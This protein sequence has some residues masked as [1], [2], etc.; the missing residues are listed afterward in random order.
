M[1][2]QTETGGGLRPQ[3]LPGLPCSPDPSHFS[4]LALLGIFRVHFRAGA[5]LLFHRLRPDGAWYCLFQTGEDPGGLRQ[6]SDGDALTGALDAVGDDKSATGP[7]RAALA[8]CFADPAFFVLEPAGPEGSVFTVGALAVPPQRSPST[9]DAALLRQVVRNLLDI[10]A[11]GVYREQLTRTSSDLEALVS[12]SRTITAASGLEKILDRIIHFLNATIGAES[13]GVLLYD[14]EQDALVLQRPAFGVID[15]KPYALFLRD[16]GKPGSGASLHVFRTLAPHIVN[17]PREDRVTHQ[18]LVEAVGARNT[19]TVPL[20][21]EGKAIGALHL[22]NKRGGGFTNEDAR[23]LSLL[24][25]QVAI[26]IHNASLL[27]K[28]ELANNLLKKSFTFHNELMDLLL[29]NQDLADITFALSRMIGRPVVLEDPFFRLLSFAPSGRDAPGLPD[30]VRQDPRFADFVSTLRQSRSLHPLPPSL[31]APRSPGRLMTM[32]CAGE[33]TMG[34]LSILTGENNLEELETIAVEQSTTVLALKI[35]QQQIAMEVEERITGEFLRAL[36]TGN[37]KS[38]QR[39][40]ERM[41]FVG[42]DL[43]K[44]YRI[45]LADGGETR[46]PAHPASEES[47]RA[48]WH[49]VLQICRNTLGEQAPES[50]AGIVDKGV[51]LIVNLQRKWAHVENVNQLAALL[52]RRVRQYI[53]DLQLRI[54]VGRQ[55]TGM[56]EIRRSYEDAARALEV[57]RSFSLPQEVT[58]FERLGVYKILF[59]VADPAILRAFAGETLGALMQVKKSDTLLTTLKTYIENNLNLSETCKALFIHPNTLKY[60]LGRIKDLAGIDLNDS[61]MRLNVQIALKILGIANR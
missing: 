34:Y 25:S 43:R 51:V 40:T 58:F 18:E 42:L 54:G 23:L 24:A 55:A 52:L 53:P 60:R 61:E 49:N 17:C 29:S 56:E 36:F 33:Q 38:G 47:R 50:I 13:G 59:D 1:E 30:E 11:C 22:I 27:Q 35:M 39:M 15:R 2:G 26:L 32:I 10:L 9:G 48:Q 4:L 5:F 20:V 57:S 46:Q 3:R 14:P 8:A 19:L 28:L 31:T 16:A 7:L 37:I 12:L 6:L 41:A 44:T 21:A 45:L